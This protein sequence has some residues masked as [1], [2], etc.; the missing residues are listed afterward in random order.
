MRG[1]DRAF[2]VGLLPVSLEFVLQ[3]ELLEHMWRH[4]ISSSCRG[5]LECSVERLRYLVERW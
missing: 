4:E 2:E 5:P 3:G 1:R